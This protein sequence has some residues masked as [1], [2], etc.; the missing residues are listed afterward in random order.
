M[1]SNFRARRLSRKGEHTAALALSRFSDNEVLSR[2]GMHLT[3]LEHGDDGSIYAGIAHA[4]AGDAEKALV[5]ATSHLGAVATVRPL[6]GQLAVAN[7]EATLALLDA[8]PEFA[9][10]AHY[11]R[12][13]TGLPVDETQ[14]GLPPLLVCASALRHGNRDLARSSLETLFTNHG[15]T[16]PQL[17]WSGGGLALHSI[18]HGE[19]L[20]IESGPLVSVVLTAYNEEDCLPLAVHSLLGQSWRNLELIIVD[21]ASTDGTLA[22]AHALAAEDARVRVVSMDSNSGTWRA[23]NVGFGHC[24]GEF[25]TLHDADDWSHARKIELQ[26]RPL[27]EALELQAT[28]SSFCRVDQV[29][30]LPF[31]RNACNYQRWNPSSLMFRR[32]V[33]DEIGNFLD[34]LLGS[35]GEYVARIETRYGAQAHRRLRLPLSIGYQRPTSLSNRFRNSQDGG[36]IVRLQHWER[37]RRSH[38]ESFS[39][40]A[41][42]RY[43]DSALPEMA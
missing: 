20:C 17:D 28:T 7:P 34:R 35:D 21:D 13:M 39:Q 11:C 9:D 1:L 18:R 23:K 12:L 40:K 33:L 24:R 37:W 16:P 22:V 8:R 14:L 19:T 29:S 38:V 5:I 43:L 2:A 30:G 31:T 32:G 3:L 10:L 4:H 6:L 27:L 41:P 15:L 42:I 25:L 26:L 36:R